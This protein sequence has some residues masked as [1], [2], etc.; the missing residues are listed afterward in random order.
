MQTSAV[1]RLLVAGTIG[2]FVCGSESEASEYIALTHSTQTVSL[3][4]PLTSLV[5]ASAPKSLDDYQ[6]PRTVLKPLTILKLVFAGLASL[7]ASISLYFKRIADR[8]NVRQMLDGS[9]DWY[10]E[11]PENRVRNQ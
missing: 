3:H 8:N 2:I 1:F 9:S 7:I 5:L 4:L 10:S 6:L 11:M